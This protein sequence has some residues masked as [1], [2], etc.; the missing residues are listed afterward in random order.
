MVRHTDEDLVDVEGITVSSMSSFQS[1]GVER[2]EL[3]AP[4]PYHFSGYSDAPR[5]QKIFDIPVA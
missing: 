5:S 4:K 3:D 2:A 1:S